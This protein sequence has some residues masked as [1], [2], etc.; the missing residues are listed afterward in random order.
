MKKNFAILLSIGALFAAVLASRSAAEPPQP[1]TEGAAAPSR[2]ERAE[3][4][5]T[6]K[7]LVLDNERT[8]SGDIERVDDQYRIK[9]LIGETW[10]PASKAL[11]LCNSLPEAYTFLR[12]RANLN[13][14]DER[15][16][17][18]DWC[19]QHALTDQALAEAQ[20]AA[21]LLDA[22]AAD[23]RRPVDP[24]ARRLVGYLLETKKR[25]AAPAAPP[26]PA[27]ALP[28]VDVTADS[29]GVF[30]ARIQP[31]LMNACA[32]CHTAGRGGSFQLTRTYS[33]SLSNR[34]ALD[35]NLAV[36][37]AHVNPRE[38]QLSRLLTKAVSLHAPGMT[39]APLSGRRGQAYRTLEKWVFETLASNPQLREAMPPASASA[40]AAPVLT[41][42]P[43]P[44]H[45]AAWGKERSESHTAQPSLPPKEEVKPK[46]ATA[47]AQAPGSDPVDPDGFNR[48]YHPERIPEGPKP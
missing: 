15:L 4:P 37:L 44:T 45:A 23:L 34:Q 27:T 33:S 17:L 48:A 5:A 29:L 30:V 21:A 28:H 3:K 18:A 10:V 8:L 35:Q 14:P 11:K 41:L 36:A 40:S 22:Q 46:S 12:S 9:R 7:V 38:P 39:A 43:P 6:G 2:G 32:N 16:R 20:A 42:P 47:P 19:R 13:D 1:S 26:P 24:R 31:I 25:A